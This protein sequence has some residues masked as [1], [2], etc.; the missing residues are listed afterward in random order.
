ML[1]HTQEVTGSSP[2][3]PTIEPLVKDKDSTAFRIAS[4]QTCGQ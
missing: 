1:I 2:V 4:I 3:A